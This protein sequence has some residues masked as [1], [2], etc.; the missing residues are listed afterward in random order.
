[1]N[2]SSSEQPTSAASGFFCELRRR[3]VYRVAAG[4]TVAAWLIIQVAATVFPALEFPS[5]A[6]RA[7]IIG[8]LGGF[9]IALVLG[10]AFDIGPGGIEKTA[11]ALPVDCPPAMRPRRL[12]VYVL[13]AIGMVMAAAV[14]VFLVP[15]SSTRQ[16]DKSIA[17]LPFS[18]LSNDP[19]NAF[20][21]DGLHD[22]VL[23][24]L[25]N[26]GELKVISRTSVLPYRDKPHS[27]RE[28]G[29]ALGVNTILEGSVRRVENRIKL[30]VQLIDTRTDEHLWA[31][32]YER[33]LFDVFEIQSALA[34][35]IAG[36]LKAK[37]SPDE[38]QR[39][40]MKPTQNNEAHM[41]FVRARTLATGSDTEERKKAIPLFEQAIELD[42]SFA[43]A[44]AQ[45]S[46]LESWIYFS[47]DPTPTHLERARASANAAM[48]LAPDLAESRVALGYIYYYGERN[49]ERALQEF[50]AARRSLPN[51]AN[52]IRAIG[53]IERRQGKWEQSTKNYRKAVSLNPRDAVLI[54][55][56]GLNH[57]ATRDYPTAAKV[58]DRAAGLAPND[59][60]I[61]ALRAWVDVHQKADF[62]RFEDL[63]ASAQ[64][65]ADTNPVAALARF[66]VQTFQRKFDEA[67]ASLER[68]PFE[69]MRG[70]TSAP[71]PKTFLAAQ[72]YRMKGDLERAR[73]AYEQVLPIAE[74]AVADSPSDA[75]RYLVVGLINAG[76]GREEEALRAGNRAAELLPET[77]DTFNGPIIKISLARIHAM[78]GHEEEAVSLLERSLK[79]P[80]GITGNELR[81][82]PTWDPLR[83]NPR[84]QKLV[85][86]G[87]GK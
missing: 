79:T 3:K 9:P 61:R 19:E 59:F 16:Q 71:L 75:S 24:S 26:I 21:A 62:K 64:N 74:R 39:V 69:N 81:F 84:F 10:W 40:E 43:L 41:L 2:A 63:L 37:L 12:N 1:M 58:F 56:L 18:N 82:D 60:E 80:G 54:R 51:D 35:E 87:A 76:L 85:A 72:V 8:V 48:R 23:T 50:E 4:Y 20:F 27:M 13:A 49:Y 73:A 57:L 38:K 45:L 31:Q 55:N 6:L 70:V 36:Q 30:V 5:W 47:I 42:P 78:L 14:G 28:I 65:E 77:K 52:V 34:Q 53:A 15:R 66:N 68:L 46:W 25:A 83:E 33:E 44:H 86:E 29:R 11:P 67:L 7:V 17:V 22:D 32:D